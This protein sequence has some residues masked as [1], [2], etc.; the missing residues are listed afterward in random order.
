MTRMTT[1]ILAVATTIALMAPASGWADVERHSGVIR[2]VDRAAGTL[3]LDEVGPWR[4][5]KGM[6]VVTPLT[7]SLV[8]ETQVLILT[9]AEGVAPTGWGGD[10]IETPS[11]DTALKPGEFVTVTVERRGKRLTATRAVLVAIPAR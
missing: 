2:V 1:R 3:V 9:R 4:I 11:S 7:V 5:E 6:T 10:Y 8:P